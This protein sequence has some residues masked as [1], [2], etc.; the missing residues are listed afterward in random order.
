MGWPGGPDDKES[1]CPCLGDRTWVQSLGQEDLEWVA[2]HSQY[3]CLGI[4]G[5]EKPGG[6]SPWLQIIWHAVHTWTRSTWTLPRGG[7]LHCFFSLLWKSRINSGSPLLQ[8]T[9]HACVDVTCGVWTSLFSGTRVQ[10]SAYSL[11]TANL[12]HPL[13]YPPANFFRQ[14]NLLN[15]SLSFSSSRWGQKSLK[16]SFKLSILILKQIYSRGQSFYRI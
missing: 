10:Q 7:E 13:P 3:C 16:T 4:H 6:Y 14:K 2:A 11:S 12:G 5:P 1:A 9:G 15:W 8:D